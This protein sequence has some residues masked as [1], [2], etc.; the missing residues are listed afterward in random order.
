MLQKNAEKKKLR[1][2]IT[3]DK[4]AN[5]IMSLWTPITDTSPI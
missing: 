3:T 4:Y 1:K 2:C 5:S